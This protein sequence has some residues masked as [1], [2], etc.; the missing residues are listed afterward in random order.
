[1]WTQKISTKQKSTPYGHGKVGLAARVRDGD[2]LKGRSLLSL[3]L[4]IVATSKQGVNLPIFCAS[5]L[6]FTDTPLAFISI[7]KVRAWKK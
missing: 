7:G 2:G 4:S 1:M 6:I 3:Q 5:S